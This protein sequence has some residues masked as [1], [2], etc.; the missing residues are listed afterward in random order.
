MKKTTKGAIAAAASASLLLG[1]AGS[2]AYWNTEDNVTAGS[3]TTGDLVLDA[4]DCDNAG[5]TVT[6]TIEEVVDQ[7]V[8]LDDFRVVPGDV[9]TKTCT[10]DV[11]AVGDNLRAILDLTGGGQTTTGGPQGDPAIRTQDYVV[12]PSFVLD[13]P[14][15]IVA[16]KPF[17]LDQSDNAKKITV[18]ITVDFPL[19]P[20][21]D[22][23][24]ND[25]SKLD[26]VELADYTVTATQ[27]R[28]FA[29]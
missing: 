27:A 5:W 10:I 20:D 9:F 25:D 3:F 1:G 14:E 17:S 12:T 11:T 4:A 22:L 13:G 21:G 23:D 7:A 6:N 19:T 18:T 28:T 26:L 2:L 16:G 15:T 24:A 29:P 8:A